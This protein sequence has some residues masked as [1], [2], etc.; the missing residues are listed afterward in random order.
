MQ[1]TSAKRQVLL[2]ASPDDPQATQLATALRASGI[3]IVIA[4]TIA[5]AAR[6]DEFAICIIILRPG[7]WRTSAVQH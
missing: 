4:N 5:L 7:Q 6:A 3:S 2:V 1:P